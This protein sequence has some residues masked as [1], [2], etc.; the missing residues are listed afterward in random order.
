MKGLEALCYLDDIAH[1]RK[2]DFDA[3][4]LKLIVEKELKVLEIIKSKDVWFYEIRMYK[5]VEE[6]NNAQCNFGLSKLT[7]Q[8]YKLIKEVLKDES[9]ND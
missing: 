1:G 9:N 2:M 3:Y 6:Y 8:E 7:Q 4:E 5:N